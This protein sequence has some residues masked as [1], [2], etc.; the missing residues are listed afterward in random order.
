MIMTNCVRR[1]CRY[2]CWLTAYGNRIM[3][4]C[5][6]DWSLFVRDLPRYS[7]KGMEIVYEIREPEVFGYESDVEFSSRSY[8]RPD[9]ELYTMYTFILTNTHDP[10]LSA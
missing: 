10:N 8:P 6:N 1:H 9:G 2:S 4:F 3:C 5:R 7:R